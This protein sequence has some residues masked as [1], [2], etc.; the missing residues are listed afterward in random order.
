MNADELSAELPLFQNQHFTSVLPL[1]CPQGW[2]LG[3][4]RG[5]RVAQ[6]ERRGQIYAV[7]TWEG[8]LHNSSEWTLKCIY[9]INSGMTHS[10]NG[11]HCPW[12]QLAVT[13]TMPSWMM[14]KPNDD[15]SHC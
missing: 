14:T 13:V 1:G 11:S 5:G 7:Q 6:R 3:E 12:T 4:G 10:E 2:R 15:V 8:E 9:V